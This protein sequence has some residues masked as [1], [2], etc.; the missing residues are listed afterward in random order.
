V[1]WYDPAKPTEAYLRKHG[2]AFGCL[3]LALGVCLVVGA[4]VALT[5]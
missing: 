5:A 3:V 2:P 1:V 4:V